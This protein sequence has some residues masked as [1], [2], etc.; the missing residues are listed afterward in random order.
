MNDL[1]EAQKVIIK[2]E[3]K[4]ACE[5]IEKTLRVRKKQKFISF[6]VHVFSSGVLSRY[7][8]WK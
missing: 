8:Q 2:E 5:E 1:H 7:L 4:D 3:L 6:I